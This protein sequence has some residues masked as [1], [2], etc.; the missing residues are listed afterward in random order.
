MDEIKRDYYEVL[1]VARDATGDDIKKSYRKLAMKFHPD[2]N[3]NGDAKKAEERFQEAKEAYE[4]LSDVPKRA[5]Y[6][7]Y[8]HAG[9]SGGYTTTDTTPP[10]YEDL[11]QACMREEQRTRASIEEELEEKLKPVREFIATNKD[12]RERADKAGISF[13]E[14]LRNDEEA[15]ENRRMAAVGIPIALAL[16]TYVG[17]LYLPAVGVDVPA[18]FVRAKESV[19][20]VVSGYLPQKP[21]LKAC[22]PSVQ[23]CKPQ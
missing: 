5:D 6:D 12:R 14:Q 18:A 20:R 21:A 11:M 3:L 2:R 7:L 1:G 19:T 9:V 16:A 22:S 10:P 17:A 4:V 15:K 23:D 13:F 8:G